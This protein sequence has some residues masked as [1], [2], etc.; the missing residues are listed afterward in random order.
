LKKAELLGHKNGLPFYDLF[1]PIGSVDK[2]YTYNEAKE[3]IVKNFGSFSEK[4]ASYTDN[5]FNKNWIDAEPREDIEKFIH[6]SQNL[7]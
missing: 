1:A 6:L 4:L 3:F 7:K 5:A 2:S